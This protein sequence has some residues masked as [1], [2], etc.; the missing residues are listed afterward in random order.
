MGGVEYENIEMEH[1]QF[2]MEAEML[3][4]GLVRPA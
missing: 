1:N 3:E 2:E 4:M